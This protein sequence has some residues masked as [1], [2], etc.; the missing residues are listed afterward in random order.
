MA[1]TKVIPKE[2]LVTEIAK[3]T[4]FYLKK[5]KPTHDVNSFLLYR[6]EIERLVDYGYKFKRIT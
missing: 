6:K 2:P 4:D 1:G 3:L 5:S